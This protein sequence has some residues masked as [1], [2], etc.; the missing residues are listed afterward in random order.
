MNMKELVIK[1]TEGRL[2]Q[3]ELEE[4]VRCLEANA[5]DPY[6]ALLIIG[7]SG[8][9]QYRGTVERY[10]AG[11]K[12]PM[13]ARLALLVLCG[14]WGLASDYKTDLEAFVRKVAWDE[15]DDVRL[16][17]ISIVGKLLADQDDCRLLRLIVGI[18]NDQS[19]SKPQILREAAYCALAL[20]SGKSREELPAASRHFDIERGLDPDVV[21][22]IVAAEQRCAE[23][24]HDGSPTLSEP[25]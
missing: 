4:T 12:G 3:R 23:I 5:C 7:R 17:A 22:Y 18:F 24:H 10:L 2:L 14:Y 20:A 13:V 8:A 9:T 16:L 15:D 21:A 6:D 11:S 25:R 1:A 19:E